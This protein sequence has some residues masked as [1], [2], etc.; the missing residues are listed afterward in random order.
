MTESH[1]MNFLL[2][3]GY[4]TAL[5][6]FGWLTHVLWKAEDKEYHLMLSKKSELINIFGILC[7]IMT[8]VAYQNFFDNFTTALVT[9]RLGLVIIIQSMGYKLLRHCLEVKKILKVVKN[10]F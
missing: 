3:S 2:G 8:S 7:L 10:D 9:W 4:V 6:I 5:I 1:L